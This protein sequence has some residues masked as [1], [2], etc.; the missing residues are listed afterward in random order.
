MRLIVGLGNPGEKFK[1]QR[2]NFGFL[3]LDN[4]AQKYGGVFRV[5]KKLNSEIA[6]SVIFG[7][8]IILA[9]PQTFM[10]QS[11]QAVGAL[12]RF[13]RLMPENLTV[14]HD[15][16]DLPF[17]EFKLTKNQ[18]AAGH[19][20]VISIIEYLKTQNFTRLRLGIRP[21]NIFSQNKKAGDL[22]LKNFSFWEKQKLPV[23]L[24]RITKNL[25]GSP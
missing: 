23:L 15:D 24:A 8:K 16:A 5:N 10:N 19:N 20:G 6:A 7:E 25:S 14:V 18:G 21:K 13:Y 4:L 17:G 11:G 2:H 12:L 9:K 1:Y 22:V 3:V